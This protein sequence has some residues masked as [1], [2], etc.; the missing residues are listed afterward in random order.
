MARCT[1]EVREAF[2]SD[3]EITFK[4]TAELPYML[5]CIEETLRMYPPVPTSLIRRTLPGR[6][7]L[8]AG[9]LLPENVSCQSA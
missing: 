6:P 2:K 8:I 7:M 4:G 5:A 1:R 9:E 3:E